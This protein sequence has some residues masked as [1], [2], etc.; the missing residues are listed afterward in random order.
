MNSCL[1]VIQ[2]LT[3]SGSPQTFLHVIEVL[4]KK[5]FLVDV[6]V[7]AV[8]NKN[9]DLYFYNEYKKI[10]RNI[11]VG[12]MKLNGLSY[13]FF[14]FLKFFNIKSTIKKNGY[15]I[16]ISNNIYFMADCSAHK[17]KLKKQKLIYYALGNV[18]I[19]S[20]FALIRKKEVFVRKYIK[21]VD[22]YIALS[23][24]AIPND[25]IAPKGKVYTLMDYPNEYFP[26]VVKKPNN[27]EIVL[28][29]IGYYCSNKNQLFSLS[30]LKEL[31]ENG[32]SARLLLVG[33]KLSEEPRYYDEMVEFID[34]HNLT[35]AVTF[36]PSD[37]SKKMLFEQIHILLLPSLFEGLSITLLEAQFSNTYCIASDSVPRDVNFGLCTFSKLKREEWLKNINDI[38][39]KNI[40][41][42]S[43]IYGKDEFENS[44]S[45]II[46]GVMSGKK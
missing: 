37:Y 17:N 36:L 28:G 14:P 41:R 7:Y 42:P 2:N 39:N 3:R 43:H 30:V 21:G 46:D 6:F 20:K 10:C 13:K 12:K 9:A 1:I 38:R 23:S 35:S 45:L 15:N 44:L 22:A 26:D 34:K 8:R 4:R 33:F 5:G 25:D 18:N 29:Q 27:D 19:Q 11:F 32:Q 40:V 31:I 24:L 16:V